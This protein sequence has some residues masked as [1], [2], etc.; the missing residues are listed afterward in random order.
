MKRDFLGDANDHLKGSLHAL[1]REAR[2][3]HDLFAIPMIT[4]IEE[5]HDARFEAYARLLR[6]ADLSR[7]VPRR[8]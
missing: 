2:A 6:L 7:V 8:C 1:L 5:W 4:D 3:V